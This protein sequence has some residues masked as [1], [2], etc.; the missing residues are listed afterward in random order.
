[1]LLVLLIAYKNTSRA[2]APPLLRKHTESPLTAI[3]NKTNSK[4]TIINS[5][6]DLFILFI[7][8]LN[9]KR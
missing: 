3:T 6:F 2:P 7:N 1:M 5:K 4:K 8:N 9:K